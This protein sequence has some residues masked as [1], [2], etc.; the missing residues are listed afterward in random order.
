M[1][2]DY[3]HE[4]YE[5]AVELTLAPLAQV[6]PPLANNNLINGKASNA[7]G[8]PGMAH[9]SV[10]S[11][12]SYRMRFINTGGN[13][14]QKV[15]IDGYKMTVIANDFIP[16]V[17]YETDRLSLA[18]GQR[19]DVIFKADG[20][21][22]DAV[23]LRSFRPPPCGPSAGG[24]EVVAAIFYEN[25]DKSQPP[26]TTANDDAYESTCAGDALDKTVPLMQVTPP[27]PDYTDVI[28][29]EFQPNGSDSDP[30]T[31]LLWYMQGQTFRIDYNDPMLLEAKMGNLS[32][33]AIRNAHNYGTNN[34]VIFVF[35][36]PGTIIHPMHLHGH[37]VFVLQTGPCAS[38]PAVSNAPIAS[39]FIPPSAT[40]LTTPSATSTSYGKQTTETFGLPSGGPPGGPPHGQPTSQGS[41]RPS[42]A[43]PPA[44]SDAPAPAYS[45]ASSQDKRDESVI[46]RRDGTG[47]CWDGS[48]VNAQNPQRRDTQMLD[49]GSYVVLQWVNDNPGVWPLH[50][51]TAWHLSAGMVWMSIEDPDKIQN[52]MEIPS[53]MA[54][55]CRDWA[56]WSGENVVYQIDTGI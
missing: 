43:T 23:W 35:E 56:A 48:I 20:K 16:I 27:E 10:K 40:A 33:P 47:S 54:Q 41:P 49:A 4:Y 2:Q 30:T 24:E 5:A 38:A 12:K 55:T 36:N 52:E 9:F 13:S 3:F 39:T 42:S 6:G 31:R 25:A 32:F 51:H 1:V 28:P 17:P 26:V 45:S 11:G 15:S 53:I 29:I 50:C 14:V 37:N 19:N 7:T 8:G 22:T 44:S 46:R 18:V 21:P 34:S